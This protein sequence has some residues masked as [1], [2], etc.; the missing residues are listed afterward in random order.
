MRLASLLISTEGV[1][2]TALDPGRE[3]EHPAKVKI[4]AAATGNNKYNFF[5]ILIFLS[6]ENADAVKPVPDG[7]NCFL[8]GKKKVRRYLPDWWHFDAVRT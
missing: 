2:L 7:R 3:P 8:P 4:I 6:C 5:F 1:P